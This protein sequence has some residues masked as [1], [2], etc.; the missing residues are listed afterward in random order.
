MKHLLSPLHWPQSAITAAP[1]SSR[2]QVFIS[3]S[4]VGYYGASQSASFT[5]D[6]APGSDYLAG[7]CKEWE[8]AAQKAAGATRVVVVRTGIVLARDGGVLARM[9]PIFELFAGEQVFV[10]CV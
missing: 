4:A 5:E 6:S 9:L 7:I 10:C 3:S 1:E 8:A 2:P